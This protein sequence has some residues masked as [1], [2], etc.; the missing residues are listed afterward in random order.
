MPSRAI[1]SRLR[2]AI[3]ACVLASAMRIAC[4]Q[5]A[6]TAQPSINAEAIRALMREAASAGARLIQF[7]EGALSGYAKSEIRDWAEVDWPA[8]DRELDAIA[9]CAA[10]LGLWVVLGSAHHVAAAARPYNSLL[11]ISDHGVLA[12]RYD[13][14]FCSHTEIT[15][16]YS[17][18]FDALVFE[19][20]GWR[21]GCALCIELCFPELFVEYF[22]RQVDC[23][24]IST[25]GS[26]PSFALHARSHAASG[27]C[28]ASVSQAVASSDGTPSQVVG[29]DGTVVAI[30]A[31]GNPQLLLCDVDRADPRWHVPLNLARPWRETA[32]E[33]GIYRARAAPAR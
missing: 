17:P 8:L 21:F 10:D 26:N 31:A 24:L 15:D 4:T 28:W 20:D 33:G 11:V 22:R 6:V 3:R 5:F 9:A 12:H 25:N 29:P 7:P 27:C 19:V 1:P 30:A 23:L 18:G 13:K 2:A 32:R 14:R 16:W